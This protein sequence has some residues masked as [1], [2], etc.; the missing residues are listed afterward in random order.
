MP[1][2]SSSFLCSLALVSLAS[3]SLSVIPGNFQSESSFHIQLLL[4]RFY[5]FGCPV[6]SGRDRKLKWCWVSTRASAQKV[7]EYNSHPRDQCVLVHSLY[8]N[9][10]P[11]LIHLL[12]YTKC[13]QHIH[14]QDPQR[15]INQ[16]TPGTHSKQQWL[17]H[18]MGETAHSPAS[19]TKCIHQ[20]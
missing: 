12:T 20:Q 13:C 10:I 5:K 6:M 8:R 18:P 9:L 19:I 2:S 16:M 15:R 11:P 7:S 3:R 14:N 4:R 17:A 1:F